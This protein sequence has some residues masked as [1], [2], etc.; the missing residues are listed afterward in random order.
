MEYK[1]SPIFKYIILFICIF[2]FIKHLKIIVDHNNLLISIMIVIFTIIFD[3]IFINNHPDLL[4]YNGVEKFINSHI[5]DNVVSDK[6]ISEILENYND[7][8]DIEKEIET[9]L[10]DDN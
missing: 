1:Y 4:Y 9:E 10:D 6:D 5:T 2:M 3:Y 8:I 7:N